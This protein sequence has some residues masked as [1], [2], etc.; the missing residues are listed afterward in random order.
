MSR[1]TLNGNNTIV[2]V[3]LTSR[4]EKAE[5]HTDFCIRLPAGEIIVNPGASPGKECV[6]LCIKCAFSTSRDLAFNMEN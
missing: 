3:L 5:K 4:I 6:A 2:V 1:R